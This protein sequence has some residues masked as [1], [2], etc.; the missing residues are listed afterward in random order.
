MIVRLKMLET[1]QFHK[2]AGRGKKKAD[3]DKYT[4]KA[5]IK[6]YNSAADSTLPVKQ[7]LSAAAADSDPETEETKPKK[8]KVRSLHW[9]S[10]FDGC[11]IM[12][13]VKSDSIII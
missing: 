1:G 13:F 9:L 11:W 4:N 2:L 7:E 6:T 12:N 10:V 3:M 8:K 5:E